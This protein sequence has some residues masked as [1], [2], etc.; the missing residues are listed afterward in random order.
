MREQARAT[1]SVCLPV[2]LFKFC[3]GSSLLEAVR[4]VFINAFMLRVVECF[5]GVFLAMELTLVGS[6][7][8]GKLDYIIHYLRNWIVVTEAKK[9]DLG[10]GIAQSIIEMRSASE[11]ATDGFYY[12]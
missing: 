5:V 8:T 10:K 12:Y 2:C 11:V 4:R 1:Q 3:R 6:L 9:D 7:G